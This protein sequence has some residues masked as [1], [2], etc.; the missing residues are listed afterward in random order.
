MGLRK[1]VYTEKLD[2]ECSRD[3]LLRK[4]EATRRVRFKADD[5][6]KRAGIGQGMVDDDYRF[7]IRL[8]A[9]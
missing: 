2:S 8:R 9:S 6:A 4:L 3:E 1:K 5:M 7:Y